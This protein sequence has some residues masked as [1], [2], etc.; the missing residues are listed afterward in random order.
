MLERFCNGKYQCLSDKMLSNMYVK[1]RDF[2]SKNII[3]I[4]TRFVVPYIQ[5][6][7][8]N[9]F[10]VFGNV[11]CARNLLIIKYLPPPPIHIY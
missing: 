8:A 4:D 3:E 6:L 10:F 1:A 11:F 5:N 9:A 7:V 2:S